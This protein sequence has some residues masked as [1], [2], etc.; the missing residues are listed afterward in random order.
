MYSSMI[1]YRHKIKLTAGNDHK[2]LSKRV[3]WAYTYRY[4]L[5]SVTLFLVAIYAVRLSFVIYTSDV[6]H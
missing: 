1:H 3:V 6:L 2:G 4:S 5:G